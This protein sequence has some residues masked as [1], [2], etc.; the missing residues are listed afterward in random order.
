MGLIA[1]PESTCPSAHFYARNG[2]G[3]LAR[4]EIVGVGCDLWLQQ[5]QSNL[6]TSKAA[7]N[8]A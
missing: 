3:T 5:A 4:F 6:L 8:S 2:A 7:S 1:A